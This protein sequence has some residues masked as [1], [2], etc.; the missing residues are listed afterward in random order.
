M[1]AP[2]AM[3][4]AASTPPWTRL[5]HWWNHQRLALRREHSE[6]ITPRL[7]VMST[8]AHGMYA[9]W[10]DDRCALSNAD[11]D[12]CLFAAS[13]RRL[14][15]P[16]G[17]DE[18]RKCYGVD[19]DDSAHGNAAFPKRTRAARDPGAFNSAE[20]PHARAASSHVLAAHFT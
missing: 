13:L 17:A 19:G 8:V 2:L 15:L 5:Q 4:T 10:Q 11:I 12:I 18:A 20:S 7:G 14:A 3:M 1:A 16:S 9:R 6:R